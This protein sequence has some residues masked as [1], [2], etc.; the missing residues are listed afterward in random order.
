MKYEWNWTYFFR[1]EIQPPFVLMSGSGQYF[2]ETCR[3]L[4][5]LPFL[6]GLEVIVTSVPAFTQQEWITF[7]TELSAYTTNYS[8]VNHWLKVSQ[9]IRGSLEK[10]RY[11]LD[12]DIEQTIKQFQVELEQH[13]AIEQFGLM[14][15]LYYFSQTN[16][17]TRVIFR[18]LLQ[19]WD[20]QEQQLEQLLAF[21]HG[22]T[23]RQKQV[24]VLTADGMTNEEIADILVIDPKVVAEHLTTI[25]SKFQPLMTDNTGRNGIR[26]R[27]IH[28]LTYL[29]MQYPYLRSGR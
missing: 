21:Y 18:Y 24:A 19:T 14:A 10:M 27:L 25:F 20:V 7:Y 17:K 9:L 28:S 3:R 12:G 2:P 8:Q 16:L 26:Y 13:N 23:D 1:H 11:L 6:R 15:C 29:L 5:T 4:L 22:L